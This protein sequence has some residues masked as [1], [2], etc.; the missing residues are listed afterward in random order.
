MLVAAIGH[1]AGNGPPEIVWD[2]IAPTI[3]KMCMMVMMMCLLFEMLITVTMK[4]LMILIQNCL[5][6]MM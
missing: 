2:S 3:E 5:L 4:M 1:V 6:N